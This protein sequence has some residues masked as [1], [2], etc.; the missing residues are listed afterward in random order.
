MPLPITMREYNPQTQIVA[1]T[2]RGETLDITSSL[3]SWQR[4]KLLTSAPG[5]FTLALTAAS[6]AKGHTLADRLR[7]MDTI[8]I[9][10]SRNGTRIDGELPIIMRGFIDAAELGTA[11][12]STGGPSEP[13]VIVSGRDYTK[14]MLEWQILY[15]FTQNTLAAK[16]NL[17]EILNNYAGFGLYGNFHL[18]IVGAPINTYMQEAFRNLMGPLQKGLHVYP[19]PELPELGTRFTFP[20][21]ILN[22]FNIASYTGSYWNLFQYLSSPP[23]G[24]LFVID[25]EAGPVLIG[26]GTAYQDIQGRTPY[27]GTKLDVTSEIESVQTDQTNRTDADVITYFLTWAANAQI[28][29]PSSIPVVI[30]G[31]QNGILTEKAA[32]YGIRP[33]MLDTPW[34]SMTDP[35]ILQHASTLNKWLVDV[36]GDNEAWWQGTIACHGSEDYRIGTYAREPKTG[37]VYY[38]A[39]ITDNYNYEG[40]RWDATLQVVRGREGL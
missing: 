10:A 33:L 31:F 2:W 14:L 6:D 18:P 9:R 13:R 28:V 16:G 5:T 24:E 7:A 36:M 30:P 40:N 8:E 25:E 27:P 29:G 38:V 21:L 3:F 26:R 15:L 22:S 12:G 4:Q 39:G 17:K 23:F 32:L 1:H 20:D 35:A 37:R 19:Y 11:M 34:L